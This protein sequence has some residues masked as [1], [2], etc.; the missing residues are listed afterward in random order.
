MALGTGTGRPYYLEGWSMK[1]LILVRHAKSSWDDPTLPDQERPLSKR[2]KRDAP[3][4]GRLLKQRGWVPDL[5]LSSQ[6]TRAI[7]T[8]N[9]LAREL[10]YPKKRIEVRE[11]IYLRGVDELVGLIAALDDHCQRVMLVGHNPEFT[12]LAKRL[13]HAEIDNVPTCGVV[14]IVFE[15]ASWKDC[16]HVGGRLEFFERPAKPA[17]PMEVEES[18]A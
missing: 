16:A 13:T 4:M 10:G 6:A 12:E 9:K 7:K 17:S 15:P 11:G 8:A 3:V 2:G 18:Q 1:N 5:I 14:S